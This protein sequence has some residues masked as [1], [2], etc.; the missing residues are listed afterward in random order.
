VPRGIESAVQYS[1]AAS[2]HLTRPS[3]AA[4]AA[5]ADLRQEFNFHFKKDQTA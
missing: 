5:I 1:Y 2:A 3:L 4:P